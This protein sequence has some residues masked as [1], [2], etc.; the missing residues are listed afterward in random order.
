MAKVQ[1]C[2]EGNLKET[3]LDI[4]KDIYDSIEKKDKVSFLYGIINSMPKCEEIKGRGKKGKRGKSEYN[5]FIGECMKREDI[6][7]LDV[8]DRMRKCASE[9]RELKKSKKG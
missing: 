1:Q 8:P 3:A 9:W 7:K 5:K 6:K 2:M 4:L